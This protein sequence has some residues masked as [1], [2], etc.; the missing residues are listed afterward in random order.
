MTPSVDC[1]LDISSKG[2]PL[3]LCSI[4]VIEVPMKLLNANG[5]S[6]VNNRINSPIDLF[7]VP[8]NPIECIRL[9]PIHP[10]KLL[11]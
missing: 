11:L 3:H 4:N 7:C 9:K 6:Y 8:A 5:M 10:S 1:S 2:K